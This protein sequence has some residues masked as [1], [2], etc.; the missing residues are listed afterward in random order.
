MKYKT[1]LNIH[2]VTITA[3]ALLSGSQFIQAETLPEANYLTNSGEIWP[4]G[5]RTLDSIEDYS[6]Y[7]PNLELSKY[8]GWKEQRVK[9]TGFFR[10]EKIDD[11]WWAVDPEGYLYISKALNTTHPNSFSSQ[12]VYDI[13]LD[14]GFNGLGGWSNESILTPALQA[15]TPLAYS[16]KFSFLGEFEGRDRGI[17]MPIFDDDW[18]EHCDAYAAQVITPYVGD[19]HVFGF[20]SDNEISFYSNLKQHLEINDN[21]DKNYTTAINFLSA[22]GKNASNWNAEDEDAYVA[23]LG[24]RYYSGVYNAIRKIDPNHMVLGSRANSKERYNEAFMRVSGKYVDIFSMNHYSRWGAREAMIKNMSDWTGRPLMITEF[25]AMQT[26]DGVGAGWKVADQKSR[27]LFYQNYVSTLMETGDVVGFHWFKFRDDKNGNKGVVTQEGVQWTETLDYMREM[28]SQI[29]DFADYIDSRNPI[30]LVYTPEADAFFFNN[31]NL[32][33]DEILVVKFS[34]STAVRQSYLRFDLSPIQ[35]RVEKAVVK[36]RSV[37]ASAV[38]GEYLAELV[39]NNSWGETTINLSNHPTGTTDLYSWTY[40][41]DV[42]IDV[43]DQINAAL[44]AGDDKL[45]IRIRATRETTKQP[46]WGSRENPNPN[47]RPEIQIDYAP[48]SRPL[49]SV[50]TSSSTTSP[51]TVSNT[52]LAQTQYLSSSATGGN[53]VSSRHT[54]LFN[55]QIGNTDSDAKDTGEVTLSGENSIVVNFDTSV[56]TYGYDI[57]NI[58]SFFGWNPS[59]G[60]RSN[61][62]YSITLELIDGTTATLAASRHWEDNLPSN[63]WT[64]VSFDPGSGSVLAKNVKAV[65]FSIA[66]N[67][68]TGGVLVAREFD[69]FGKPSRIPEAHWRMDAGNGNAAFDSSGNGHHGSI[70]NC[71]WVKSLNGSALS[72]NGSNSK[73]T[74]PSSAFDAVEDEVTIA[75]W[76]YGESTQAR[77]DTLFYANNSAGNRVLNAHLPWNNSRVYWDAGNSSYD[78]VDKLAQPSQFKEA[79]NHWTFTKNASTGSMKV[80]LNGSLWLSGADK[81]RTIGDVTAATLGASINTNYYDGIIDDVYLYASELSADEINDLYLSSQP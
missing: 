5:S 1:K 12:E 33:T 40:G 78:R 18:F 22:R 64:S 25:Y 30:D 79:W 28:N 56:N 60:G 76:V 74:L 73:V 43:T 44:A 2:V 55:G 27:G 48:I 20:M 61:Q 8:G 19:P 65:T 57:T 14:N 69:V 39:P 52:D 10:V 15:S 59:S 3:L 37:I 66:N 4:T 24:E 16:P 70:S 38:P 63:Y 36:L 26:P 7:A 50:V 67:A 62:G 49:D 80:Y 34:G 68:N 51:G 45:S 9:A 46:F 6:V 29:Y 17:Y 21:N 32:G 54:Q 47:A 58:D 81:N 42:S 71:S 31:Q 23:L 11:R 13:L 77:K 75:M 35:G 53:S 41:D 72:F